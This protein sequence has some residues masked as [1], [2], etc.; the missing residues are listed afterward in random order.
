MPL[1]TTSG[2]GV[3]DGSRLAIRF[4]MTSEGISRVAV[5]VTYEALWQIDPS[6]PPDVPSAIGIFN[7][8]RARIEEVASNKFD[9]DGMDDGQHEGRPILIVRSDDLL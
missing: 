8:N 5:F 1:T 7:E 2:N 6:H 9:S 4:W 3:P